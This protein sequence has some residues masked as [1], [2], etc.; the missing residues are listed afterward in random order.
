MSV[1]LLFPNIFVVGERSSQDFKT[2]VKL[3][4]DVGLHS[5]SG[6]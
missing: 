4:Q 5:S 2:V 1:S 6:T 3:F